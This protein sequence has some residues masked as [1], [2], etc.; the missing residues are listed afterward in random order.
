M[1]RAGR[2]LKRVKVKWNKSCEL[3]QCQVFLMGGPESKRDTEF[4]EDAVADCYTRHEILKRVQ[5]GEGC[6]FA[7][8]DR[9]AQ[10]CSSEL[11]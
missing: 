11:K 7:S 9:Q 10:G 6:Y 8:A 5:G 4:G 1:I 3:L 2:Q